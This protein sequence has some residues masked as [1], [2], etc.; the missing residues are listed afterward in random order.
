V[1]IQSLRIVPKENLLL[2]FHIR[3]GQ[4]PVRHDGPQ[5]LGP[6]KVSEIRDASSFPNFRD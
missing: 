4:Q 3:D 5:V 6:R 2:P 1:T